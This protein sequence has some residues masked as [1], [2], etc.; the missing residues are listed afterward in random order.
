MPT[1][2]EKKAIKK[3]KNQLYYEQNKEAIKEKMRAN[4]EKDK[5]VKQLYYQNHRNGI[6]AYNKNRYYQKLENNNL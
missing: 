6:I 1:D 5:S 2:E 3:Q 4:Y